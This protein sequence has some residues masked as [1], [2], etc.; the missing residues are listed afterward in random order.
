MN[1]D[2]IQPTKENGAIQIVTESLEAVVDIENHKYH[3]QHM[4]TPQ[5]AR[6]WASYINQDLDT[7]GNA[8]KSAIIAGY[9]DASAKNI[10]TKGWYKNGVIFRGEL[11]SKAEDVLLECLNMEVMEEVI[12]KGKSTGKYKVNNKLV[13][14]RSETAKFVVST[15][16]KSEYGRN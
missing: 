13:L 12:N 10:T 5:R 9:T 11:L 16:G 7:F 1:I 6:F 8:Y 14:I 4:E 3:Y 2:I 15:L